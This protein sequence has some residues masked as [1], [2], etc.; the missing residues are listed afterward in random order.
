MLQVLISSDAGTGEVALNKQQSK[1]NCRRS[2]KDS[3]CRHS[4]FATLHWLETLALLTMH[5]RFLMKFH[6]NQTLQLP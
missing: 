4:L 2:K 6:D 3:R 5:A 1:E